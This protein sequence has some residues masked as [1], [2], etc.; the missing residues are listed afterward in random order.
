MQRAEELGERFVIAILLKLNHQNNIG[1]DLL[2]ERN[3]WLVHT[4]EQIVPRDFDLDS[5][6]S[7]VRVRDVDA[8]FREYFG[9]AVRA[10]TDCNVLAQVLTILTL[11][12]A[13]LLSR[14][15][16]AVRAYAFGYCGRHVYT[17]LKR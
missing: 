6:A 9:S 15:V 11:A 7:V 10:I 3:C 5:A 13:E 16:R 17:V 14:C 1:L 4:E 12:D 8:T 2:V